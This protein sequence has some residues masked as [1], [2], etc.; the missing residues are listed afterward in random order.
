MNNIIQQR[1][2]YLKDRKKPLQPVIV[3]IGKDWDHL[4]EV[5]CCL[6]EIKWKA[7]N[8]ISA[9]DIIFK[10]ILSLNLQYPYESEVHWGVIQRF[11]YNIQKT[12]IQKLLAF[13]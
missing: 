1:A 8:V 5:L 6:N 4:D 11:V 10:S 12:D 13:S 2:N 3:V 9:L 7:D